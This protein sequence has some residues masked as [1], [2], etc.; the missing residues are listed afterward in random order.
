M[1]SKPKKKQVDFSVRPR[2]NKEQLP[3][4]ADEWVQ[5]GNEPEKPAKQEEGPQKRLTLNLP[6]ELHTA[7]KGRC[8]REGETIQDKVRV[9]IERELAATQDKPDSV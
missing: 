1:T 2:A 7:F 6:A 8:V 5:D 4:T 9:L 3:A